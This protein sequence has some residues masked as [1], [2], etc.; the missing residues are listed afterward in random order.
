MTGFPQL[1]PKP[2]AA[3]GLEPQSNS[4]EVSQVHPFQTTPRAP[5]STQV[6]WGGLQSIP[7][8]H[9]RDMGSLQEAPFFARRSAI[10]ELVQGSALPNEDQ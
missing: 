1:G 3:I 9:R 2:H 6:I 10:S 4:Q 8:H 5:P 7:G